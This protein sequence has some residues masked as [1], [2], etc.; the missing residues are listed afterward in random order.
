MNGMLNIFNE[1]YKNIYWIYYF[2]ILNIEKW[3]NNNS[4]DLK[5]V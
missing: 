5:H 4:T 3:V 2:T 1:E